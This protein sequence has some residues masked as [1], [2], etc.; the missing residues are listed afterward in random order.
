[1]KTRLYFTMAALAL[2]TL[3]CNLLVSVPGLSQETI[4][5]ETFSIGEAVPEGA[6]VTE[7]AFLMAPSSA[8]LL[9]G[10]GASGPAEGEI[11]YN[12]A[13]WKPTL[14]ADGG[15]LSISQQRPNE[16]I[17]ANPRDTINHWDVRVGEGLADVRVECPTGNFTLDLAESFPDGARITIT[18]GVGNL[19]LQ[20][21]AGA[22]ATVTV[23]SGLKNVQTEGAWTSDGGAYTTNGP[24]AR[25]TIDVEMGI[26]NLTLVSE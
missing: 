14:T 1:M 8:T 22:A 18:K 13:A 25:W 16:D 20:A 11:Q 9:L 21:P 19:R 3:A 7:A 17:V 10:G 6:T 5:T 2:A 15:T 23:A 12:L 26:G 4:P 24:G